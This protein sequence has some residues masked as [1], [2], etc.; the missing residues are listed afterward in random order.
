MQAICLERQGD[1]C[2]RELAKKDVTTPRPIGLR[3]RY[4]RLRVFRER[5]MQIPHAADAWKSWV[6]RTDPPKCSQAERPHRRNYWN[7]LA[8]PQLLFG[9]FGEITVLNK[10]CRQWLGSFCDRSEQSLITK[11]TG[12]N[13]DRM[14]GF[15]CE[16]LLTLY[17]Q[18]RPDLPGPPTETTG[19]KEFIYLEISGS[20]DKSGT[21][22]SRA[23]QPW[24]R[25]N[26][27][28]PDMDFS[29]EVETEKFGDRPSRPG[30][31]QVI[32]TT[33]TVTCI[34]TGPTK[35]QDNPLAKGK[36]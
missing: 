27:L 29:P 30:D 15:R 8:P 19:E 23:V 20:F 24:K 35:A 25:S 21:G 17:P 2:A 13:L 3:M 32:N 4:S 26:M 16:C 14:W 6:N 11:A 12:V 7:I 9:S 34:S 28:C 10:L 18:A 31:S 1:A 36:R 22:F 33:D 5:V